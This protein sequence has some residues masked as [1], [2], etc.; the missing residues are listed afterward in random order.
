M[1]E[2]SAPFLAA[3]SADDLNDGF[4]DTSG[5]T[6][7]GKEKVRDLRRTAIKHR[8]S[9]VVSGT[10]FQGQVSVNLGGNLLAG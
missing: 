1:A 8:E 6:E 5:H 2:R 4:Y 3:L 7:T 10:G 9:I